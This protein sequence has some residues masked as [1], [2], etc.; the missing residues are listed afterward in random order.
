MKNI[1][2]LIVGSFS[3]FALAGCSGGSGGSGGAVVVPKEYS[4]GSLSMP[5]GEESGK[6]KIQ[7]AISNE[8]FIYYSYL[9]IL[10]R[11]P[12]MAGF[13]AQ[14]DALAAGVTRAQL[15]DAMVKSPEFL[16]IFNK[17]ILEKK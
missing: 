2:Y 5:A 4:C 11:Q 14:C 1:I 13:K 9:T 6:T 16:A 8:Q 10:D 17:P 15:I 12:E 3:I 7:H